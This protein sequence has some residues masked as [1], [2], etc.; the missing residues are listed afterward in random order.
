[1]GLRALGDFLMLFVLGAF[2]G[3]RVFKVV[4]FHANGSLVFFFFRCWGQGFRFGT[5]R[6]EAQGS[7]VGH[8]LG[9]GI[10][11]AP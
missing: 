9:F 3:F 10:L 1:M 7:G 4:F 8:G 6:L 5:L 11:S 2:W